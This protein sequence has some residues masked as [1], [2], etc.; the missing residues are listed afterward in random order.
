[1]KAESISNALVTAYLY[2][3]LRIHDDSN[4]TRMNYN[5]SSASSPHSGFNAGS[6]AAA[7]P[8]RIEG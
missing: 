5:H 3:W 4:T 2:T 7:H 6:A 1:M 8:G